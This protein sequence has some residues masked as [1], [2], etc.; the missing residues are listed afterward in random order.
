[1]QTGPKLVVPLKILLKA[2][3]WDGS[4]QPNIS[5][6]I[7]RTPR[8]DRSIIQDRSKG[9][10]RCLDRLHLGMDH[11]GGAFDELLP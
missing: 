11:A 10:I 8:N 2:R 9:V 6:S 3:L 7:V 1:M 4:L 5:T